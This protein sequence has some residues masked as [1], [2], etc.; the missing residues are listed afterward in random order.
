[1]A[2]FYCLYYLLQIDT[3]LFIYPL[4]ESGVN[5]VRNRPLL[6]LIAYK[7][8]LTSAKNADFVGAS[9]YAVPSLPK[10]GAKN[11]LVFRLTRNGAHA[12]FNKVSCVPSAFDPAVRLAFCVRKNCTGH[13][14][15]FS[16]NNYHTSVHTI[17]HYN[18]KTW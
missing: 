12:P 11:Q 5:A 18:H 9:A 4:V 7:Y 14:L 17:L 1:M 8:R 3:H 6:M 15:P 2:S 13:I 10:I 16:G